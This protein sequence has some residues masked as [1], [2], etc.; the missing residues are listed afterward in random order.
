[1]GQIKNIKLHIV[2]DIKGKKGKSTMA[3]TGNL[4]EGP[5]R[6]RKKP[7]GLKP[8]IAPPVPFFQTWPEVK[9]QHQHMIVDEFRCVLNDKLVD[10][11]LQRVRQKL[12]KKGFC[13]DRWIAKL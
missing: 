9:K 10:F 3:T 13:E 4:F 12:S 6:K 11:Y 5:Q 1:M 8:A 7:S 2:T